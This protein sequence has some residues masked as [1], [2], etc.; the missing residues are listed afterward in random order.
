MQITIKNNDDIQKLFESY[1]NSDLFTILETDKMIS[2]SDLAYLYDGQ[3]ITIQH[4]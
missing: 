3:E 4:I 2:L 1:D